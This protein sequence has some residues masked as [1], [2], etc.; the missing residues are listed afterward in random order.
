MP[1]TWC[2]CWPGAGHRLWPVIV[3]RYREELA[4][5]GSPQVILFATPG[6]RRRTVAYSGL[7][8]AASLF[9][10]LLMPQRFFQ[11]MGLAAAFRSVRRCSPRCCCCPPCSPAGP[12]VNRLALPVLAKRSARQDDSGGWYRFSKS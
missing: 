8:V 3:S 4:R 10:L 2:P 7:T 12:R 11:N 1:P 5:G 6:H 9:C